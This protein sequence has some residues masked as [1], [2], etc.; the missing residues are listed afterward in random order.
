M[1]RIADIDFFSPEVIQNPSEANAIARQQAPVYK[2]PQ[3]ENT[4]MVFSYEHVK[5]VTSQPALFSSKSSSPLLGKSLHSEACQAIYAQGWPQTPT[6]LTND[7]PEH[8]RFRKLVNNA[9]SFAKVQ[10]MSTMMENISHTLIDAF[11]DKGHCELASAFSVPLPVKVIGD[12]LGLPASDHYLVKEWSDAFV[13]LIGSMQTQEEDI[14][15]AK[16]VVEFQHYMKRCHDERRIN[17]TQDM[18]SDL[19]Y[20]E[21]EDGSQLD[22][23]ELL[24]VS[25]QLLV[26]GNETTTNL[27]TGGFLMLLDNPDQLEIVREEP[28]LIPNMVEEMLRLE[29]PSNTM[30]RTATEDTELNGVCIPKGATVL[31]RFGSA[32]RDENAFEN[33][34]KFDVTRKFEH[35]HLA[36][37]HGVHTC[38]G[39]MLARKE[40]AIAFKALIERLKNPRLA[41]G[42]N[43]FARFPNILLRGLEKL[44]IEFDES[45]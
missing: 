21:T 24:N 5:A 31:V 12:Q 7:P 40:S 45:E 6:L 11:I 33:P 36:F 34:D 25:Q 15:S 2:M 23:S 37:G 26:A 17:K 35:K 10:R 38:I 18:L 29:S 41:T 14:E 43:D 8:N 32:N 39:A 22:T 27:I 28:S 1:K 30:W 20:A 3:Q 9:F 42:K 19:V 13:Q 44:H 4:Y 16:R